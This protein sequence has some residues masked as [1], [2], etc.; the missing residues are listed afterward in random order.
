MTKFIYSKKIEIEL[1]LTGMIQVLLV[2]F[3]TY[4][5]AH[6]KWVGCFIVGFLISFVWTFNVKKIAF[7]KNMERVVYALGAAFGTVL[8]L[9]FSTYIYEILKLG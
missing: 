6:K 2:A 4:Q 7:G 9:A 1:F 8:G 5:L 3:N